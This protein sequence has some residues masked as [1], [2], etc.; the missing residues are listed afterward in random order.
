MIHPPQQINKGIAG[1]ARQREIDDLAPAV[2]QRL[3]ARQPTGENDT[4]AI[5]R[6]AFAYQLLSRRRADDPAANGVFE[7]VR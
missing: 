4:D 7:T 1:I 5:G 2:L 3:V 6:I